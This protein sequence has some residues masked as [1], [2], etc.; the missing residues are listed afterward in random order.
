MLTHIYKKFAKLK[1]I[2][3]L[4]SE[5]N[6]LHIP[7]GFSYK[8][9][10]FLLKSKPSV[11]KVYRDSNRNSSSKKPWRCFVIKMIKNPLQASIF[12]QK[13]IHFEKRLFK[14]DSSSA[15]LSLIFIKKMTLDSS[16]I[17]KF[18]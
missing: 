1:I 2:I 6:S 9:C 12:Q 16:R 17:K 13:R 7:Y 10:H 3:F 5:F 8:R 18:F 4:I 14:I 15:D 11:S